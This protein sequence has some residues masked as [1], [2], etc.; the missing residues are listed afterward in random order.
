[1]ASYISSSAS[2]QPGHFSAR[3]RFLLNS[4]YLLPRLWFNLRIYFEVYLA[5]LYPIRNLPPSSITRN[6]LNMAGFLFF[7]SN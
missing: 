3:P 5:K 7:G 6:S 2:N 1:M 4:I